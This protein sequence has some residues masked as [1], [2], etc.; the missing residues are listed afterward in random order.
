MNPIWTKSNVH[1]IYFMYLDKK[2]AKDVLCRREV[3]YWSPHTGAIG[4]DCDAD[5]R[6]LKWDPEKE[7]IIGDEEA[8]RMLLHGRCEARGICIC[9]IE[10]REFRIE[11]L[12]LKEK[13][14]GVGRLP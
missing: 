8:N 13:N 2:K 4:R 7:V 6:K 12:E 9:R 5:G 11:R 1:F 10:R 3:P 14:V